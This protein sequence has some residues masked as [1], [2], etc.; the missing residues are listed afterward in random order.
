MLLLQLFTTDS[1]VEAEYTG[2]FISVD[3]AT[4]Q[5]ICLQSCF[6]SKLFPL[7]NRAYGLFSLP[8]FTLIRL[9]L[10]LKKIANDL[11]NTHALYD[12]SFMFELFCQF[13]C[14][15]ALFGNGIKFRSRLQ[16][17]LRPSSRCELFV[18]CS[19]NQSLHV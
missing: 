14:L 12:F 6:F 15:S 1:C 16:I 2:N 3:E 11:S 18:R 5:T 19:I 7:L 13:F 9:N 4:F 10:F 8:T 17:L